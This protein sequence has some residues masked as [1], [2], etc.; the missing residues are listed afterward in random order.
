MTEHKT[1]QGQA[2]ALDRLHGFSITGNSA[3]MRQQMLDD[4]FV[5][6]DIAILGQWTAIFGAPNSGKTLLTLFLLRETLQ[7]AQLDPDRIFYI[8]ADDHF[9]GL[10]EKVGLAEE[11]GFHMLA[12][13]QAGFKNSEI[14][15]LMVELGETGEARGIVIFLDTAKKFFDIMSK[16]EAADFGKV[17]RNFVSSGGS[18]FA[19]SHVNKHKN[20]EGKSIY[21]GVSDLVDDADCAFIADVVAEQNLNGERVVEF[22][23]HKCRGDV[24]RKAT[25]SYSR[26][27]GQTYLELID[28][29]RRLD[30]EKAEEVKLSA[31]VSKKLDEDQDAITAI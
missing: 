21:S 17:S 19:L 24:A 9:K 25:F 5:L 20:S 7:K 18:I 4:I 11:W 16:R 8:N 28:S 13:N 2:T 6:Q 22:T 15:Q 12:P 27:Q 23:N 1:R 14:I 31:A 3:A 30:D 10:T 29:V 26:Q